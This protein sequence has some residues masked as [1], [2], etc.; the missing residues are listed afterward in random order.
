[1]FNRQRLGRLALDRPGWV[2][3]LAGALVCGWLAGPG[4]GTALGGAN[5]WSDT[6]AE[7]PLIDPAAVAD[8]VITYNIDLV[9]FN[10]FGG[11]HLSEAEL[12][13]MT[14]A[15][16][17][18]FV[19]W[20]AVIEPIGL[21]F[22]ESQ[23]TE[24]VELAVRAIP[25][26]WVDVPLGLQDSVAVSL[27]LPLQHVYTILPIWFDATENLA[28][29][30]AAPLVADGLLSQPYVTLV[31]SQQYDLHTVAR[32]SSWGTCWAWGT[33]GTR[34]EPTRITIF[35]ACRP[36][37]STRPA[38]SRARGWRE[39]TRTCGGRSWRRSCRRS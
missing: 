39:C 3:I 18:A 6:P 31:A 15:V 37:C 34:S 2:M 4:A 25:Y 24:A 28:D 13:G 29:L 7:Y 33:S 20:N 5:I 12:A 8:R 9:G 35:W 32:A 26:D 38:C 10:L 23:P 11:R 36:S 21:Q 27:G 30:R 19:A 1:M 14:D 17:Q 22:V 16:R